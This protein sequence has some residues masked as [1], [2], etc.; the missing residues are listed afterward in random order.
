VASAV[1]RLDLGLPEHSA[2]FDG[3]RAAAARAD[4]QPPFS[5]QSLV[6]LRLGERVGL[7]V[8]APDAGDEAG[9]ADAEYLDA[10]GPT[11]AFLAVALARVSSSPVEAELVVHP[12][13]RGHGFGRRLVEELVALTPGELLVWAHGDH[14]GARALAARFSFL[15]VREL[16]Q[17]RLSPVPEP[18]P[19]PRA[20]RA[21]GVPITSFEPGRDDLAWLAL[22][23]A[24]FASHPEQ[25]GLTRRDLEARMAEAWFDRDDFL[26]ARD[27][28]GRML[29]FCWLKVDPAPTA[30]SPTADAD[31]VGEF[32][33]VAV[34]PE[35]QGTGLGRR[36]M[37]AGLARLARRGI[38]D[39]RLYVD[40]DNTAAVRLYRSMGFETHTVDVQ[41]RRDAV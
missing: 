14:P 29:G 30:S 23:A 34:A 4:G 22:N 21:P 33:A 9:A 39:A 15:P 25:G 8:G 36:L 28:D 24:A 5:D 18:T 16:L 35:G 11:P 41:Y 40:A 6:E 20:G 17:L 27:D 31:R 1:R 2:A 38:R 37:T 26:I 19:S 13:H 10:A 3:L 7:V 32:Y 12:G